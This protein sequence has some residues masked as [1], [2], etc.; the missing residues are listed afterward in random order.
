MEI[1]FKIGMWIL[2]ECLCTPLFENPLFFLI[3]RLAFILFKRIKSAIAWPPVWLKVVHGI[4]A[5]HS[6]WTNYKRNCLVDFN[7]E[8][9]CHGLA[10]YR[11]PCAS[12][13][14]LIVLNSKRPTFSPAVILTK[15]PGISYYTVA[16][17]WKFILRVADRCG[18]EPRRCPHEHASIC[19]A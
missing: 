13:S 16:F 17:F 3:I 15:S 1:N 14:I 18:I 11:G 6:V 7:R 10:F 2:P 8:N 19:I 9:I 5:I 4:S 12:D